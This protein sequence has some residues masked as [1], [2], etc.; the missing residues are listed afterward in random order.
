M[1]PTFI[2]RDFAAYKADLLSMRNV[3]P[4]PVTTTGSAVISPLPPG[5]I[6]AGR[7]TKVF[8]RRIINTANDHLIKKVT[9]LRSKFLE[10]PVSRGLGI[11]AKANVPVSPAPKADLKQVQAKL[12][13]YFLTPAVLGETKVPPQFFFSPFVLNVWNKKSGS[14]FS[15]SVASG[16]ASDMP[17]SVGRWQLTFR[18]PPGVKVPFVELHNPIPILIE[19]KKSVIEA[20]TLDKAAGILKMQIHVQENIIPLL[21]VIA[22]A[23][24]GLGLAGWG[25]SDSIESVDKVIIDTSNNAWKIG[26]A[27]V[28]IFFAGKLFK[29]W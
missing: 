13:R 25:L 6:L 4:K 23:G 16:G 2:N 22:A 27:G 14:V 1:L 17:I 10:K 28:G 7:L 9:A 21:I 12:E 19:K 11:M 26:L 18:V 3:T 5:S 15:R 29:L 8:T 24:A 20:V